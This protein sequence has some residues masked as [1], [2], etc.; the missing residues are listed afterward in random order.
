M[1]HKNSQKVFWGLVIAVTSALLFVAIFVRQPTARELVGWAGTVLS[2]FF[3]ALLAFSFNS[4]RAA[5]E[6]EDKECTA[7]NLALMTLAAF[8]NGLARYHNSYIL[9]VQATPDSW[10]AMQAGN[11]IDNKLAID[12]P[13]LSFLLAKHEVTWRA[14]VVEETR[15]LLLMDRIGQ[16]N[17][18]VSETV[19]PKME[20]AGIAH[21]VSTDTE[22]VKQILGPAT[23]EQLKNVTGFIVTA[24]PDDIQSLENCITHLRRTLLEI[25]PHRDFVDPLNGAL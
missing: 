17:T 21:G 15:Y 20:A 5:N 2:T 24:C 18:L 22:R 12:K 8:R 25:Y 10:Y 4:F 19:W 13:S 23:T 7:G 16:R 3:G 14:V 6:R 9:P 1:P 11:L